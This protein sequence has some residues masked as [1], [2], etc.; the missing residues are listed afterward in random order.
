MSNCQN[1]GLAMRLQ[2]LQKKLAENKLTRK[3]KE[4]IKKEIEELKKFLSF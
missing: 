3:E 1:Y 2:A 4:E